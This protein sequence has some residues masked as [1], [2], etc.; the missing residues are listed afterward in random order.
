MPELDPMRLPHLPA[1]QRGAEL[2]LAF[3]DLQVAV[4]AQHPKRAGGGQKRLQL[5]PGEIHQRGLRRG[6]GR[7]SAGRTGAPEAKSQGAIFSA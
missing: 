2:G 3:I 1:G 6:R 5:G 4:L 7:D